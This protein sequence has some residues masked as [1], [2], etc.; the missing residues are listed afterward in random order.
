MVRQLAFLPKPVILIDMSVPTPVTCDEIK[1]LAAAMHPETLR[2]RRHLHR[3]PELSF[4]E[5]QSAAFLANE[6]TTAGISFESGIGGGNG[7]RATIHGGLQE[8]SSNTAHSV[9][10]RADFDALPIHEETGLPFASENPGVMHACG[11]DA[12]SA[13]V[14]SAARMLQQLTPRFA[15]NV[16][17]LFQPAE[18]VVPGGARGMIDAGALDLPGLQAII[19]QHVNPGLP[20]GKIGFRSGLMMASADDFSVTIHGRGGHGASPHL[21]IDPVLVAAQIITA[22]QQT[23]SRWANPDTP[24]VLTFGK[25]EGLGATNVIPGEVKLE[26]TFRTVDETW[27]ADALVRIRSLIE[28]MA[29][30]MG[31]SASVRLSPGYPVVVNDEALTVRLKAA[32]I[33]LLGAERVVDLP[34]VM[35]AEDFAYYAEKGPAC[36]YNTGIAN[37]QNGWTKPLHSSRMMVDENALQ[38]GAALLAWLALSELS[39]C[40]D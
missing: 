39:A 38:D 21:C 27:R 40:A 9:V 37:F 5:E 11:H 23:V 31:A 34:L 18:E 6:L 22:L 2:V 26:G 25:I 7:I 29:S 19:G 32:A 28:G 10:L 33:A 12:H 8:Q 13:M 14:L 30:A 35:W 1:S 3:H 4:H 17:I 16:F 24:S 36:F 15:G 20:V